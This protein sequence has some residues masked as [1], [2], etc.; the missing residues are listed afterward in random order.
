MSSGLSN[1]YFNSIKNLSIPIKI[2]VC[3]QNLIKRM[4]KLTFET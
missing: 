4:A 3:C 2:S 1:N